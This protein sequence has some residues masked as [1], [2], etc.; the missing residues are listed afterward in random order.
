M[1]LNQGFWKTNPTYLLKYHKYLEKN[2]TV[3]MHFYRNVTFQLKNKF[4]FPCQQTVNN[5]NVIIKGKVCRLVE[6]AHW[7]FE[8]IQIISM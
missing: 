2:S 7:P 4:S 6:G 8:N 3:L 5:I 1:F